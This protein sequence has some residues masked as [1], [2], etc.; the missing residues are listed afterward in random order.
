MDF[1]DLEHLAD[2]LLVECEA[3]FEPSF[4]RQAEAIYQRESTIYN[5]IDSISA[6]QRR[7]DGVQ[8]DQSELE[9]S[10]WLIAE[11]LV[12]LELSI[13]E[14]EQCAQE[15]TWPCR[16]RAWPFATSSSQQASAERNKIYRTLLEVASRMDDPDREWPP[17]AG[18]L[19]VIIGDHRRCYDKHFP[20]IGVLACH[21]ETLV[22]VEK[23]LD[24]INDLL[25]ANEK[26]FREFCPRTEEHCR[27]G[28]F[29]YNLMTDM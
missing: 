15:V 29:C 28:N 8:R 1:N 13:T 11:K 9:G 23:Q 26:L 2:V 12:E 19:K 22:A 6:L 20:V 24:A 4:Y 10:V 7:L 25:A 3:D 17:V 27:P 16:A 14:Q 21:T 5:N 18:Q